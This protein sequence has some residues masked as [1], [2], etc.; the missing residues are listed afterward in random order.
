MLVMEFEVDVLCYLK[1]SSFLL[2]S[3]SYCA[4]KVEVGVRGS[5]ETSPSAIPVFVRGVPNWAAVLWCTSPPVGDVASS[6]APEAVGIRMEYVRC[7]PC[8][9]LGG[10][11][12]DSSSVGLGLGALAKCAGTPDLSWRRYARATTAIEEFRWGGD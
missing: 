11:G 4:A 3:E 9:L 6:A 2:V 5:G 10:A 1:E 7:K 8:L 12:E